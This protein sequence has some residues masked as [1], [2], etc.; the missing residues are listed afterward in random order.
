MRQYENTDPEHPAAT[1]LDEPLHVSLETPF[2]Y[3]CTWQNTGSQAVRGGLT[4]GEEICA[5]YVFYYPSPSGTGLC[6]PY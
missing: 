1:I 2:E 4:A 5:M 3:S 6:L